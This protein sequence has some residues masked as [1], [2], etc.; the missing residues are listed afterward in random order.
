MPIGIDGREQ[1]AADGQT[2][3]TINPANGAE[4][5]SVAR[6]READVDR[7]VDAARRAS[8]RWSRVAPAERSRILSR[9]ASAVLEAEE[10]LALLETLD[11]GKPLSQARSDVRVCARYFEYYAGAADKI[12]GSTIPLDANHL[13]YTSRE[14]WGVCGIIIPWNYP[15]QMVGRCVAAA[16][17]AGNTVVLKPAE[18]APMTAVRIARLALE[19]GLPDG[20]FNAVPG[21]GHDAGAHLAAHPGIDHLSFTGSV[22]TG[23]LVMQAAAR[24]VTPIT[25]ELGGKS[26]Q[27]V[28]A[29][30]DLDQALSTTVRA[31]L[32]NA[33]QTCSA[34]SRLLVERQ[35]HD[36]AVAFIQD[37]FAKVRLG[38]GIADPDLGPLIT[39]EQRDR[40]LG[41]VQSAREEGAALVFGGGTPAA[42]EMAGGFFVEPTLFADVNEAMRLAQEEV[43]GPVL[44]VLPF[45][46]EEEAVRLA[47]GTEY[48][49]VAGVWTQDV[50]RAHRVARELKAGQVFINSYGAA[51]GVEL[52]FGGYKRSG[53]GREKGMEGLLS[54]TQVKTVALRLS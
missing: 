12:F 2:F 4:L 21:F 22:A 19:C 10:E 3:P 23:T 26:P 38:P 8:D 16:L 31:I 48:G 44:A 46:S 53:F 30:A 43:F 34:G 41:Y 25:L 36:A 28:F 13:V 20:V 45:D 24:R 18:Q 27:I 14:P 15:L 33:G 5:A 54:Y 6:A 49:L 29:D 50:S 35:V 9:I 42:S 32:Q 51:G 47:N 37:A 52:P 7:A 40:V 39:A 17:A 11:T 1:P